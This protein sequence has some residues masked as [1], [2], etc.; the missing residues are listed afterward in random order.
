MQL[1]F[2]LNCYLSSN[3]TQWYPDVLESLEVVTNPVIFS[4]RVDKIV[5][6]VVFYLFVFIASFIVV[7]VT[8]CTRGVVI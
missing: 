2:I 1:S 5:I 7:H 6:L 8:F 3:P 4:Y